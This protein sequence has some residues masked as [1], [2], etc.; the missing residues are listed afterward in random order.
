MKVCVVSVPAAGTAAR[1]GARKHGGNG[2]LHLREAVW[3]SGV[4]LRLRGC[5]GGPPVP[6]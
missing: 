4:L 2:L 6:Q 5:P 1:T 3:V